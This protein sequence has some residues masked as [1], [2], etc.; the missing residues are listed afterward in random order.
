MMLNGDE[1]KNPHATPPQIA[2]RRPAM[3][4]EPLAMP[5]PIDR[6]KETRATRLAARRLVSMALKNEIC[7]IAVCS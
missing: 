4:V 2:V 1:P 5:S 3:G 7:P 6:A